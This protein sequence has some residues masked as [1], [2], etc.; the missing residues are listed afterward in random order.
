MTNLKITIT[1]FQLSN[2]ITAKMS[3]QLRKS[4]SLAKTSSIVKFLPG[5]L[6][7]GA[8]PCGGGRGA[9]RAEGGRGRGQDGQGAGGGEG[10]RQ[11]RGVPAGIREDWINLF[12]KKKP[13]LLNVFL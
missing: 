7:G 2:N 1:G 12:S 8:L 13:S 6:L 10:A 3:P 4:P 11:D 5:L 9:R